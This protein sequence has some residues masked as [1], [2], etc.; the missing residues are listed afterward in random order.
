MMDAIGGISAGA[1]QVN[2]SVNM[3]AL[4]SVDVSAAQF[5]GE[6]AGLT[7][8][9]YSSTSISSNVQSLVASSG[10]TANKDLM[11]ALLLLLTMQ[12]LQSN[13]PQQQKDILSLLG[14]LLQQSGGGDGGA[15][16]LV[17]T[18]SSLSIESTSLQVVSSSAGLNA[19]SGASD[20]TAQISGADGAS[21][22]LDVIA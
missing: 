16:T 3:S 6:A 22:G 11:N 20:P 7:Q 9:D 4:N 2:S 21:A 15:N 10:G 14:G 19:Y 17:Y 13:D 8:I 5:T 1:V 18:S 12:Y